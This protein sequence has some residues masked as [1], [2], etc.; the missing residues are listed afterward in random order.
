MRAVIDT[1]V[2]VSGL[3]W[4]GA[5]HMLLAQ[6]RSGSLTLVS[7]PALLAELGNVMG[8]AKFEAIPARSNTSREAT[9]DELQRLAELIEPP[10]LP[11]RYAVMWTTITHSPWRSPPAPI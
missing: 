9:L 3:L 4:H 2:L 6:V 11:S 7:S 10:P 8:R 5:P 1:N